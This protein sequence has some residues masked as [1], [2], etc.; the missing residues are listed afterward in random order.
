MTAETI[1]GIVVSS[2]D[3]CFALSVSDILYGDM[4][5]DRIASI[6]GLADAFPRLRFVCVRND[7]MDATMFAAAAEAAADTGLGMILESADPV[8]LAAGIAA[9]PGHSHLICM[10]DADRLGETAIL[11]VARGCPVSV[12]GGDVES[13]MENVE[14]VEGY[15]VGGIVLCPGYGNMKGCL[16]TNTD[17]CRLAS[18]GFEQAC[19]PILTRTWSG[20]YALS[21]AS[22]SVM[23]GGALMV[24][25]DLDRGSCEVLETLI[26]SLDSE[27]TL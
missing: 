6:R 9:V 5:M 17:L 26:S 18:R 12:P 20:E 27:S 13:L 23:R 19:H 4:L 11:S 15:G 14:A 16:E 2:E 8:C 10:T 24:L 1:D 3:P 21:V 22:V 7:S 25:D